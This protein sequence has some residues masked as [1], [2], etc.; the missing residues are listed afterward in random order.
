[1]PNTPLRILYSSS[2]FILTKPPVF[3]NTPNLQM[4]TETQRYKSLPLGSHN[5]VKQNHNWSGSKLLAP[6]YPITQFRNITFLLL[7]IWMRTKFSLSVGPQLFQNLYLQPKLFSSFLDSC[8]QMFSGQQP[9]GLPLTA[10]NS[11]CPKMNTLPSLI[12]ILLSCFPKINKGLH[13][14]LNCFSTKSPRVILESSTCSHTQI[15]TN[16]LISL[17]CIFLKSLPPSF[18]LQCHWGRLPNLSSEWLQ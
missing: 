17:L 14:S 5:Y 3:F 2:Y 7:W 12:T 4:K 9:F 8:I 18:H 11:T 10:S 15:I 13:Y 6:C 1:M 16:S